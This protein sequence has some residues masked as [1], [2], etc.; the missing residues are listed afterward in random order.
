MVESARGYNLG[1]KISLS[2]E[3]GGIFFL[4][5]CYFLFVLSIEML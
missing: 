5:N 3:E 1:R 2:Q 4:K